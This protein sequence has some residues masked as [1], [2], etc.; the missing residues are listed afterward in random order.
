M[1]RGVQ[2]G[3]ARSS[4]PRQ[5]GYPW[6]HGIPSME[7]DIGPAEKGTYV[8]SNLPTSTLQKRLSRTAPTVAA[9]ALQ[10][11]HTCRSGSRW[12][13]HDKRDMYLAKSYYLLTMYKA[14]P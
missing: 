4:E 2:R 5:K 10:L 3:P 7:L 6:H 8:G 14:P 11:Q 9:H 12:Y 13:L 1:T